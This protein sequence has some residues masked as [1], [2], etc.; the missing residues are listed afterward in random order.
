MVA[1]QGR[2]QL[3][4]LLCELDGVRKCRRRKPMG[5][6][7]PRP[8]TARQRGGAVPQVAAAALGGVPPVAGIEAASVSLLL[9]SY[10]EQ[11]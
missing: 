2:A 4:R 10:L 5:S 7:A 8:S 1:G 9:L 6:L 11:R 3:Q